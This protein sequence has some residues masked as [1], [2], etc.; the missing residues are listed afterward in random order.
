MG[1]ELGFEEGNCSVP[2]VGKLR[3]F[4]LHAHTLLALSIKG[5]DVWSQDDRVVVFSMTESVIHLIDG[6]LFTGYIY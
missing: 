4:A 5:I 2:R 3:D 6:S 1:R